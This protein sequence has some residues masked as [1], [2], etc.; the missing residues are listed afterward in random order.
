M[1][2]LYTFLNIKKSYCTVMVLLQ[3]VS[4]NNLQIW[5]CITFE[6]SKWKISNT[7]VLAQG[8]G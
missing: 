8:K 2:I 1:K 4:T 3:K 6:I 7:E 5:K